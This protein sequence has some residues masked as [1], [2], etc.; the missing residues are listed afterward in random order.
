MRVMISSKLMGEELYGGNDPDSVAY[1][2][3]KEVTI[4]QICERYE[5]PICIEEDPDS[6]FCI[7]EIECIVEDTEIQESDS[8]LADLFGGAM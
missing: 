4:A 5:F 3:G 6:W 7:E 1:W 8:S 2:C